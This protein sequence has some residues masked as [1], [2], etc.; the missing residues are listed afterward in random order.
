MYKV[1]ADNK[2]EIKKKKLLN[3][4]ISITINR[5]IEYLNVTHLRIW[6]TNSIMLDVCY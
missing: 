1:K 6:T 3:T 4:R 5:F 2:Y